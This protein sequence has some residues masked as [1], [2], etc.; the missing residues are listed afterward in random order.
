MAAAQQIFYRV[1]GFLGWRDV[2][3]FLCICFPAEIARR[4]IYNKKK[5]KE[6]FPPSFLHSFGIYVFLFY[7]MLIYLQTGIT[8]FIHWA[9]YGPLIRMDRIFLR[10]FSSSPSPVP[11]FLNTL[12]TIPLGFML[13]LLWPAFRS[14]KKVA[15][16]G[17]C[18]S[19]LIEASQLFLIRATAVD[20]LWTNTLGAIIGYLGWK[21]LC[22]PLI[23]NKKFPNYGSKLVDYEAVGFLLASYFGAVALFHPALVSHIVPHH[24]YL[25]MLHGFE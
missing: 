19:F 5:K 14:L 3:L 1:F 22:W 13:P 16:F 17:F 11:Y 15:F 25:M 9:G 2:V 6:G 8:G 21:I 20:D 12:M 4:Y 7:L 24:F 10:P 18:F 23:T